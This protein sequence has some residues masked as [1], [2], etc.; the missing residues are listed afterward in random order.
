LNGRTP[1]PCSS[2]TYWIV[3]LGDTLY[4]IAIRVGTNITTLLELNP[5]INPRNLQIGDLI[6]LPPEPS[7]AS[8]IFWRVEN[9]D[10]LDSIAKSTGTTTARLMELNPNIDPYN[11]QIGYNLCLPG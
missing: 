10:T 6:C 2:G 11:L 7:C 3:K 1:P 5:H 4:N 9:G 8:G